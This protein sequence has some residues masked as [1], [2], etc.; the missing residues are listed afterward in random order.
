MIKF[1]LLPSR[2]PFPGDYVPEKKD[3]KPPSRAWIPLPLDV[4]FGLNAALA[5][6][7]L[8]QVLC[9]NTKTDFVCTEFGISALHFNDPLG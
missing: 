4:S 1:R 5:S 3:R 7:M 2:E 9:P 6:L 8:Y